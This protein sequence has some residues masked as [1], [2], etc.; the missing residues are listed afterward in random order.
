MLL[1]P[2]SVAMRI[3]NQEIEEN[4]AAVRRQ[5]LVRTVR[6]ESDGARYFVASRWSRIAARSN[7]RSL[8]A[9]IRAAV[10]RMPAPAR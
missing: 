2:P 1:P 4:L 7:L 5:Q 3:A 10:G 6:S 8:A 9:T